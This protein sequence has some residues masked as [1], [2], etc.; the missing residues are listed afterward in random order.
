MLKTMKNLEY[1]SPQ[2]DILEI[3]STSILC[4]SVTESE[5]DTERFTTDELYEW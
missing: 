5:S 3:D 2:T 4:S 1:Q